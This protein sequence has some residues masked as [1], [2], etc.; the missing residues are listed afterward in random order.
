MK[1]YTIEH[2]LKNGVTRWKSL[3]GFSQV[4]QARAFGG[5]D[6]LKQFGGGALKFRLVLHENGGEIV[7]E[8]GAEHAVPANKEK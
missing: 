8:H 7:A 6:M 4:S 1:R 5:W 2:A 3:H